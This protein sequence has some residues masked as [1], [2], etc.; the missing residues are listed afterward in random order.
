MNN[1]NK[2]LCKLY[3]LQHLDQYEKFIKMFKN[4]DTIDIDFLLPKSIL[5]TY[6]KSLEELKE[7]LLELNK[8]TKYNNIFVSNLDFLRKIKSIK[9]NTLAYKAFLEVEK[10]ETISSNLKAFKPIKGYSNS[11]KYDPTKTIT[12][13]LLVEQGS[14]NILTLPARCRKIFDSSW[15]KEGSLLYIDF[16]SLEPRLARKL[17]GYKVSD[18]LYQEIKDLLAENIDR[19]II[20]KATI[21]ILYGKNS[22]LEGIS[23]AKSQKVLETAKEYF[24]INK[25]FS[26]ACKNQ[27]ERFRQNFYGRP[28]FNLQEEKENKIINNFLQSTAVDVALQFFSQV[29]SDID[30][31]FIRPVGVIHDALI[32]DIHNAHKKDFIE[33]VKKGYNCKLLGNFPVSIEE[34]N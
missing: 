6:R 31:N 15:S 19:S 29:C 9:I 13:R 21:S 28:I 25:L 33:K 17:L 16:N 24:E 3:N 20:K 12:G 22:N 4:K 14:P 30:E 7:D 8:Q 27:N 26:L 10:N 5:K 2:K 32:V 23:I 34:L 11:I 18:D 1:Y